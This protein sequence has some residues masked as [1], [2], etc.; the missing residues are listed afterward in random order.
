MLGWILDLAR[1][2]SPTVDLA[3]AGEL[4]L[5]EARRLF[6]LDVWDPPRADRRPV[7]EGWRDVITG[8]IASDRGLGWTW[9]G[10]YDGDGDYEWCGSFAA[11]C[12]ATAGLPLATR[13]RS[14]SSCLRLQRWA[15]YRPG[16]D[17]R[18]ELEPRAGEPRRLCVAL[19]ES[20]RA[21]PAGVVPQAGDV[22]IVGG[23]GSGPGKHITIVESFDGAA[24]H[25][26]EGNGF[27]AGPDGRRRQGI[28]RAVRPLGLPDG[29][30]LASYHARWLVR[31]APVD[32]APLK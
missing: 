2:R 20:S 3:A 7:A 27:G 28:V 25:T 30:G 8:L 9:E 31:P 15:S 17:G 29:A 32:L 26:I 22:L 1:R 16:I 14:W 13:K 4:A 24:F 10:R 21:L 11:A 6:A 12:W 18:P 23:V 19:T 5:A